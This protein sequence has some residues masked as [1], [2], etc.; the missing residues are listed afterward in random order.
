M[1]DHIVKAYDTDLQDLARRISEM[2]GIAESMLAKAVQAPIIHVNGENIE[3]VYRAVSL[4]VSYQ[5]K[6]KKDIMLDIIC[7]RKFGHNELD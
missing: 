5:S 7:Y 1:S 2:G 6:F 4:A 3:D